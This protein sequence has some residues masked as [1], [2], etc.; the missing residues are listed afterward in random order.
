M[1]SLWPGSVQSS[2][3]VRVLEG[4]GWVLRFRVKGP[5]FKN[6]LSEPLFPSGKRM[7]I[8]HPLRGAAGRILSSRGYGK[9]CQPCSVTHILIVGLRAGEVCALIIFKSRKWC[10]WMTEKI[11]T[12]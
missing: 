9:A 10:C 6:H 4:Q 7:I 2:S 8:F 12:I 3:E 1:E 5:G 11:L